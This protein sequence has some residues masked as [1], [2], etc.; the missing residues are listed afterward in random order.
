MAVFAVPCGSC[1]EQVYWLRH[2][3]TRKQAPINVEPREDGNVLVDFETATY[4]IVSRDEPMLPGLEPVAAKRV[5][6]FATCTNADQ[7]RRRRSA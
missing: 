5:S 2:E 6:H 3:R 4:R 7:H 1:G